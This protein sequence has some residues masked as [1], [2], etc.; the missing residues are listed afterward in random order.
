M[1]DFPEFPIDGEEYID[2][3]G[4]IWI[5]DVNMWTKQFKNLLRLVSYLDQVN[6]VVIGTA[7][8][9][10][11]EYLKYDGT[12]WV[13]QSW[14]SFN[15][16]SFLVWDLSDYYLFFTQPNIIRNQTY[17][18]RYNQLIYGTFNTASYRHDVTQSGYYMVRIR[19]GLRGWWSNSNIRLSLYK[20]GNPYI[21]Y[22]QND[23]NDGS[24]EAHLNKESLVYLKAGEYIYCRIIHVDSG[25]GD[26]SI[27]YQT[28]EEHYYFDMKLIKATTTLPTR[29]LVGQYTTVNIYGTKTL[30]LEAGTYEVMPVLQGIEKVAAADDPDIQCLYYSDGGYTM[31][32]DMHIIIDGNT[33]QYTHSGE[34]DVDWTNG[35]GALAYRIANDPN[36]VFTITS[37]KSVTFGNGRDGYAGYPLRSGNSWALYKIA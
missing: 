31:S 35:A 17:T 28:P 13:A 33:T 4:N 5:F 29:Y 32:W 23:G 3:N 20:N 37:T 6:D 21:K 19:Y 8:R 1:I 10:G 25:G 24:C 14:E 22:V 16:E 30:T 27:Y 26:V 34:D 9:S 11:N 18:I 7:V 2:P 15:N 12:N 36:P